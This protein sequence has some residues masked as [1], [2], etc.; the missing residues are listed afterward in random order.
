MK[1][2]IPAQLVES[3]QL[4]FEKGLK[5]TLRQRVAEDEKLAAEMKQA[6]EKHV[7]VRSTAVNKVENGTRRYDSPFRQHCRGGR[8]MTISHLQDPLVV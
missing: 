8:Y 5:V 2:A 7:M 3:M 6:C 1:D 4:V